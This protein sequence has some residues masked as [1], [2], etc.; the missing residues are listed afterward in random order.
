MVNSIEKDWWSANY[1]RNNLIAMFK[2]DTPNTAL[3]TLKF[4]ASSDDYSKQ[5]DILNARN[6][7]VLK[8][9]DKEFATELTDGIFWA[10]IIL[11]IFLIAA[12]VMLR[13]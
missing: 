10:G 2:S 9:E 8:S 7:L 4:L 3:E 12:F 5:L 13:V 1:F 11:V 6:L